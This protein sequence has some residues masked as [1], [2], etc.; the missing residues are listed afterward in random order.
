MKKKNKLLINRIILL[1]IIIIGTILI[2]KIA[3][4]VNEMNSIYYQEEFNATFEVGT[5]GG[6]SV[7]TNVINFGVVTPGGSSTKEIILYHNYPE[8]LK[9]RISSNGNIAEVLSPI[10]PFLLE[11]K[12]EKKLNLIA[13]AGN[14]LRNYTGKIKIILIKP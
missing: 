14:E 13:R 8:P 12:V 5:G 2:T 9:V 11:P 3:F 6:F 7:D 1:I 10:P 4:N